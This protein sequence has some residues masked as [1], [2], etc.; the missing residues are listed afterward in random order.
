MDSYSANKHMLVYVCM[1]LY[2][3]K[4]EDQD[5]SIWCCYI[6]SN[7]QLSSNRI[8]KESLLP[9]MKDSKLCGTELT[10]PP[11]T[12]WRIRLDTAPPPPSVGKLYT[13]QPF[14][15]LGSLDKVR[16]VCQQAVMP[17][18]LS[19]GSPC[20]RVSLTLYFASPATP[21]G[22]LNSSAL[23]DSISLMQTILVQQHTHMHH[24]KLPHPLPPTA[25]VETVLYVLCTVFFSHNVPAGHHDITF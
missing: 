19:A 23:K 8:E 21:P 9:G 12:L 11:Q 6:D 1:F 18:M 10:A 20:V 7:N 16:I 17:G 5:S 15:W 2:I 25:P 3:N 13:L 14:S 4:S 22:S 24:L